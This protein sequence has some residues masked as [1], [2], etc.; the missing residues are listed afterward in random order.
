ME[1]LELPNLD[2]TKITDLDELKFITFQ[3]LNTVKYLHEKNITHRDLK[4]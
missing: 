1:Y 4:P 2:E 3:L